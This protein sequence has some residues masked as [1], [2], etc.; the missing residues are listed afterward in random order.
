MEL[1]ISLVATVRN[2]QATI[3]SFVDSLLAQSSPPDEIIIV[4]GGS[5]DGTREILEELASTKKI[6]TISQNCNIAEGRNLG[7]RH[8]HHTLIAV[9]DAGCRVDPNW[10]WNI[11]Q[12]FANA[13]KPDVVAGNFRF[14]CHSAFEEAVAFSTFSPSRETSEVA[15]YYPSSRSAAFRKAAWEKAKGYPEW[16]YAAEDTL[17]NIRLRQLGYKFLFCK[18]A[19]VYWR[20]RSSWSSLARQR[21]N[22]SRGNARVGFG[23]TGYLTN[24]QFHAVALILILA[25]TKWWPLSIAALLVL[26]EHVRRHLW[27]QAI[28]AMRTSNKK[29]MFFRVLAIMEFVRIVNIAGFIA[30]RIDRFRDPSFKK[31]QEEWMGVNSLDEPPS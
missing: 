25:S 28:H 11:Q 26:L 1:K 3:R 29:A 10:L 30:G 13:A 7:I 15:Q 23:T 5:T 6:R 16:L 24:V 31:K 8:A 17:L 18:D 19:I 12:C 9:T 2:E 4:D 22:F 27:R 14:D 21:F 20:P